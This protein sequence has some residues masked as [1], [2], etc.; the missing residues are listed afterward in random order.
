MSQFL[1]PSP[2]IQRCDWQR[3]PGLVGCTRGSKDAD[4]GNRRKVIFVYLYSSPSKL[5]LL[6]VSATGGVWLHPLVVC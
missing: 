2:L 6:C 3:T 5:H 1:S 4:K